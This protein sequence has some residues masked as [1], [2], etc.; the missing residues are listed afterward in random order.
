M[1]ACSAIFVVF[2]FSVLSASFPASAQTVATTANVL[3]PILKN[4]QDPSD[5][6]KRYAPSSINQDPAMA[7]EFRNAPTRAVPNYNSPTALAPANPAEPPLIVARID[8]ALAVSK[9]SLI[10]TIDGLKGRL[11]VTN[12]GSQIVTPQAQFAVCNLK[13][14]KIAAASKNGEALAPN[15]SEKI[16]IVATNLGA[17]DLKL[18][19]ITAAH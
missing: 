12:V 19:K 1:K 13:G 15:D 8:A 10:G 7:R 11:Y 9:I 2:V 14:F 4:S 3:H 6:T 17:A 5:P 18:I 16:E